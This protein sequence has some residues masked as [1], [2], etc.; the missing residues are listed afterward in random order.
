M[1]E[2][3]ARAPDESH[4]VMDPSDSAATDDDDAPRP[5]V[6]IR[7][8]RGMMRLAELLQTQK[9]TTITGAAPQ[10]IAEEFVVV[11][12]RG[13]DIFNYILNY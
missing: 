11:T 9:N 4:A 12:A 10:A 2:S 13:P 7:A 3:R 8:A 6:F 5:R 1:A